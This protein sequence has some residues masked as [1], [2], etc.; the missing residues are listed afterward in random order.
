MRVLNDFGIQGVF[1]DLI[2][3]IVVEPLASEIAG[4]KAGVRQ[5]VF[6]GG[7]FRHHGDAAAQQRQSQYQS[8]QFF[9]CLFLLLFT[10]HALFV[11]HHDRNI[12]RNSIKMNVQRSIRVGLSLP[13]SPVKVSQRVIV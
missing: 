7:G 5:Q 6:G 13:R 8:K 10:L 4:F 1:L 9:H 11:L 3:V 12:A 2:V